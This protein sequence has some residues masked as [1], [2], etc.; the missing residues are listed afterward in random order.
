MVGADLDVQQRFYAAVHD[1]GDLGTDLLG[2]LVVATVQAVA[3]PGQL[4]LGL[5]Q[6]AFAGLGDRVGL[7]GEPDVGHP[8]VVV[9]A[10]LGVG[11]PGSR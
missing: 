10:V 1:P 8:Q 6:G 7:L 3:D 2:A 11:D 9:A 4:G 5:G